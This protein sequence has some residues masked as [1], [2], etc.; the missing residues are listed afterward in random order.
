[1]KTAKVKANNTYTMEFRVESGVKHSDPL[2]PTL[3]SLVIDTVLKELDLKCNISIRLRQLTTYADDI[4]IIAHTK[5]SLIDTFQQLKDNSMEV[6]LIINEKKT[7]YLKCTKKYT[8][9]KNLNIKTA[10]I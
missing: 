10:Y 7:K 6:G 3:F 4:L 5:Q 9:T 2:C 1:L 8:R